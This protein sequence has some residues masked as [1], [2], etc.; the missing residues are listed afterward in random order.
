MEAAL[1]DGTRTG[2]SLHR[3]QLKIQNFLEIPIPRFIAFTKDSSSQGFLQENFALQKDSDRRNKKRNLKPPWSI[4]DEPQALTSRFCY[5]LLCHRSI[6]F[7]LGEPAKC[8]W[9]LDRRAQATLWSDEWRSHL[10]FGRRV[11]PIR[12]RLADDRPLGHR[13]EFQKPSQ[14]PRPGV[15]CTLRLDGPM[16]PARP[17]IGIDGPLPSHLRE[18]LR[19]QPTPRR[20]VIHPRRRPKGCLLCLVR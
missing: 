6:E 15:R 2:K 8:P 10:R 7:P 4:S 5:L 1:A 18:L 16:H 13:R 9:Q 20:S 19:I 12:C 17:A 14:D 3:L 11:G